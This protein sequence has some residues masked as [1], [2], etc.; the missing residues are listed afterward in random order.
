MAER[1]PKAYEILK[2]KGRRVTVDM[3]NPTEIVFRTGRVASTFVSMVRDC[4]QFWVTFDTGHG[5]VNT[6]TLRRIE[7][8]FDHTRDQLRLEIVAL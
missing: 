8:S 4:N 6:I 1:E 5:Q 3:L 7:L 2:W